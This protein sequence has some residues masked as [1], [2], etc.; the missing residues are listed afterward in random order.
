MNILQQ[1]AQASYVKGARPVSGLTRY[2]ASI[3]AEDVSGG[4]YSNMQ[5]HNGQLRPDFDNDPNAIFLTSHGGHSWLEHRL[6]PTL[7][8]DRLP[9]TSGDH[10][11]RAEISEWPWEIKYDL[12]TEVWFGKS[13]YIPDDVEMW[14]QGGIVIFQV[15]DSSNGAGGSSPALS[16]ELAYP[17]QLD[18]GSVIYQR[19]PL[20]G[21]IQ[22][23]SEGGNFRWTPA[24]S[25]LRFIPGTRLDYITQ[26][27]FKS[28]GTGIWRNWFNGVQ[29]VFPGYTTGGVTRPPGDSQ[30]T[31]IATYPTVG[32]KGGNF[33]SPLYH[34]GYKHEGA[35]EIAEGHTQM[36]ILTTDWKQVVRTPEDWDYL[37]MNAYDAVDTS[38][39]NL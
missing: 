24:D 5:I 4:M 14:T 23:I 38:G 33:K 37:N 1:I 18:S 19:T 27:L 36:R 17:G 6:N 21:E 39:Y 22:M 25:A 11:F 20:G 7:P 30:I 26:V 3:V 29:Y 2:Y 12:D 31:A 9:T 15:K 8:A 10:H 32:I 34:L 35:A 16:I 28:D 13:Y